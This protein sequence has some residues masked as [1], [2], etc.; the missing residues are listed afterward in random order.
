M[1]LVVQAS[2]AAPFGLSCM[3]TPPAPYP[4]AQKTYPSENAGVGQLAVFPTENLS[5]QSSAPFFAFT[6]T[7]PSVVPVTIISVSPKVTGMHDPYSGPAL[8]PV[9]DQS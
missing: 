2:A 4:L 1:S 3:Q 8:N 7:R 9:L 5:P 6:A